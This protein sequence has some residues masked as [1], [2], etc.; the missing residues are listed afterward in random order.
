MK[1][2]KIAYLLFV[3]ALFVMCACGNRD[4]ISEEQSSI[5][6][7]EKIS[8]DDKEEKID[9]SISLSISDITQGMLLSLEQ[10]QDIISQNKYTTVYAIKDVNDKTGEPVF[11]IISVDSPNYK[12]PQVS[13]IMKDAMFD[14]GEEFVSRAVMTASKRYWPIGS[15]ELV[16]FSSNESVPCI[17]LGMDYDYA[18]PLHFAPY[19]NAL[20]YI[21][22][23]PKGLEGTVL[24]GETSFS[25]P[26]KINGSDFSDDDLEPIFWKWLSYGYYYSYGEE[27]EEAGI[28]IVESYRGTMKQKTVLENVVTVWLDYSYKEIDFSKHTTY[29]DG[30]ASLGTEKDIM[31]IVEPYYPEGLLVGNAFLLPDDDYD[32]RNS[33][34]MGSHFP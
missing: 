7:S 30:Y 2:H 21:I 11:E 8:R 15:Q 5:I 33:E 22:S 26:L 3:I 13:E 27:L 32:E 4:E 25:A 23:V 6:I 1:G 10:M 24:E 20:G 19:D 31:Q 9:S 28:T 12:V 14:Y 29:Q 18:A 17:V 16:M 34:E